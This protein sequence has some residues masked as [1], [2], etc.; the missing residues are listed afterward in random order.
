[1]NRGVWYAAGAYVL[2]GLLPIFWKA[3]AH[4]PTLEILAHR[5]VWALV[6]A[7]L[8]VALR[9]G[10]RWIGQ[11]LRNRRVV[12][13]FVLTAI[14]LSFNWGLY[15]WS[16]NNNHVVE[17]SLGYFINPLVN[18]FLGVVFLR[19]RLRPGQALAIVVALA[20]VSF[21]TITYGTPPWIALILAGSF[22][23][24]GLLRKTAS[25]GS[26]EGFTLET[27]AMFVPAFVFLVFVELSTGGAFWH[28]GPWTTLLLVAS[29][30]ATA[31]PLLLFAAGARLVT[32]TTLGVLQYIAPTLQFLLGV[33]LYG[34]ALSP[35]RLTGFVIVWIA[36]VIYTIEGVISS[37][38]AARARRAE[39]VP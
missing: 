18:V 34:E 26:L 9:G 31:A 38:R 36:L 27:M 22:G 7:L 33:F 25:L 13:V 32:M 14:L 28:M 2:W 15:I 3:L 39:V 21:L 30:A 23:L 4:V 16:V 20:G 8:L 5:V 6:V 37:G 1:M 12:G 10:W 11:A 35:E 24:Y 29:G 17:A 19:E